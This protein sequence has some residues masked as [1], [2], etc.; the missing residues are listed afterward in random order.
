[1][2]TNFIPPAVHESI[3]GEFSCIK[4]EL[5]QICTRKVDIEEYE[6]KINDEAEEEL[7][8]CYLP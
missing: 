2:E 5:T 3:I 6:R 1:M 8:E 7:D 4:E